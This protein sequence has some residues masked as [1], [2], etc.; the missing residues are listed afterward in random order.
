MVRKIKVKDYM[1]HDV[2]CFAPDTPILEAVHTL[3]T[4][5]LSG[6][7]VIDKQG[8]LVGMLSD[9]DCIQVA[10][11]AAYHGGFGGQVSEFM[12]AQVLTVDVEASVLDVAELIVTRKLRRMPVVEQTRLVGQISRHD[13]LRAID[14][15]YPQR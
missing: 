2:V 5:R 8:N 3:V 13:V 4:R 11:Q 14:N 10:L 6:A 15:L 1:T 7:P 9:I 12:T